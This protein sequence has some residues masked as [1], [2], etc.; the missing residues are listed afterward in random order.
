MVRWQPGSEARLE[1]FAD[2]YEPGRP[3]LD[4]IVFKIMPDAELA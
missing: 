2:Y 3:Y 4:A 1:R